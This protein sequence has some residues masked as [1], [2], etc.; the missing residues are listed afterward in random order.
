[1][2]AVQDNSLTHKSKQSNVKSTTNSSKP[3]PK[4]LQ[5]KRQNKSSA[6]KTVK[7][8]G[9]PS[10]SA[11]KPNTQTRNQKRARWAKKAKPVAKVAP[12]RGP[13]YEYVSKCC[14]VPCRKVPTGTKTPMLD[15]ETGKMKDVVSGLGKWRC[16]TCKK[17]CKVTRQAPA[18]V[19]TTDLTKIEKETV[20]AIV[21]VPVAS[22]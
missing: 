10:N 3:E 21:E 20:E 2:C 15:A 19:V 18:K 5:M 13:V 12:R 11:Q 22:N 7:P 8:T 9:K 4:W 17:Y 14:S 6:G 1:M 16:S